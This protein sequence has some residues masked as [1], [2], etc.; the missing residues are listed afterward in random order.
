MTSIAPGT[1]LPAGASLISPFRLEHYRQLLSRLL[2]RGDV[3]FIT[4]DDLAWQA[5]DDH[6]GGYP[7]EW[8]AWQRQ[9]LRGSR[10]SKTV[11]LLIQHDI[12]SGPLQTRQMLELEAEYGVRSTTMLF[13][14]WRGDYSAG[15]LTS[16]PADFAYFQ[17]I[18]RQGFCFGYHCNAFHNTGFVE[19]GVYDLFLED[20][21]AL[22]RMFSIRYF[23]PHGGERHNDLGNASF[24]YI[25][26][27]NIDLKHVHNGCSPAFNSTFSDGGLYGRL[28]KGAADANFFAWSENLRPGGR[29]RLLLHPQYFS[30]ESFRAFDGTQSGWYAE[31]TKA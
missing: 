5:D 9:V 10:S 1:G 28:R 18:E 22:R 6:K 25:G 15:S 29:Y 26:R 2:A 8:Q 20:V 17:S 19:Q 27:T 21:A 30:D 12:D 31:L 7:N 13:H 4:Y 23:S 3:E 14:R 24:D 11:H 16:Y